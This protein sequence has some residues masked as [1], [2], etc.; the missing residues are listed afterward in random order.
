MV[1]LKEE[2]DIPAPFERLDRWVDNFEEEFVKWSP[3]HLEC[4]LYNGSVKPG[5]KV[6]FYEIV[7]GMDYDVT[8]TIIESE[9]DADHFLIK[10]ESDAKTAM[11]TFEGKRTQKGCRFSHTE[12]FGMQAPIIG[13]I[14]NFLI[15]KVFYRKKAN[16]QLI[17][18]DMILDNKLLSDIL[19]EG[20]YPERMPVEE[21]KK[22]IRK[23]N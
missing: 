11:I 7:M 4:N 16:W 18:D 22:V 3:F 21:L 1:T 10:F 19:T 23:D 2:V 12:M 8:G 9:R 15:F 14:M 6:R 13:L 17:R 20:K 5:D